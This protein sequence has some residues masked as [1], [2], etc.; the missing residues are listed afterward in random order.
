MARKPKP[1]AQTTTNEETTVETV[2]ETVALAEDG[3]PIEGEVTLADIAAADAAAPE[4][5]DAAPKAK[6][7]KILPLDA[8]AQYAMTGKGT[9]YA[10]AGEKTTNQRPEAG[11]AG[12]G[13]EWYG[14]AAK[15][16]ARRQQAMRALLALGSPFTAAQ[17]KAAIDAGLADGSIGKGSENSTT[18]LGL[19]HAVAYF[20]EV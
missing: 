19:C 9:L 14:I 4:A 5:E 16:P 11:T 1:A 2:V 13:K 7:V 18:L 8:T 6:P 10:E 20:E 3:L 15:R 12:T 17:A